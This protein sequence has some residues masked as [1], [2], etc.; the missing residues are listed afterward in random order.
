MKFSIC[1]EIYQGMELEDA[2]PL[3]AEEGYEAVE[4]APFTVAGHVADVPAERRSRIKDKAEDAGIDVAG[5]HWV[6]IKPE[7]LHMTHIDKDIR[8][9][10]SEYF[11]DLVDFCADIGGRNMIVG[12]PK[13]RNVMEGVE[14]GQAWE[15]ALDTFED[16]VK[17]A[18]DR[19]VTICIEPLAAAETNFINTAE[20]AIRFVKTK[21][22]SAFKIILDVKAMCTES[23]PIPQI[24][25]ESWPEFAHFHANDRNLK[26]PG[27]GE[28][29]FVPIAAALKE[30]GYD[31]YVSVEV[32]KFED[33][34][35]AIAR[36]SLAYLKKAFGI[37]C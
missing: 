30:V 10:T 18:E 11:C 37:S 20:D 25:K 2:I 4:V 3:I 36:A 22:S 23:K 24:I 8:R 13:Q 21:Q 9:R 5:I 16:P 15:W 26:G 1:N 28:V 34:Y 29:D 17:R 32:F 14:F 31:G 27:F 33:G 35:A 7:G 19:G 6:L 12:S